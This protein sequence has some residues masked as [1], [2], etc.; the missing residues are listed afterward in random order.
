MTADSEQSW[1]PV[2][3]A[4]KTENI[5]SSLT[6]LHSH[7][8]KAKMAQPQET[9]MADVMKLMM[10]MRAKDREEERRREEERERKEE[11]RR[12]ESERR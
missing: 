8:S 4:A 1:T 6:I 12:K 9:S 2:K 7:I 3:L 5:I 10:E 11:E